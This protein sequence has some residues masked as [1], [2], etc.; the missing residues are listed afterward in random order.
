MTATP[1]R[2]AGAGA[3]LRDALRPDLSAIAP[4]AGLLRA[5]PVVV[6]VAIGMGLGQPRLALTLGVGANF[7]ATA[8]LVG[9]T[10]VR[11]GLLFVDAFGLGLATFVGSASASKETLHLLLLALWSFLAGLLVAGGLGPSTAG[12]QS[13]I[14]FVVFGRFVDS[15]GPALGLGGL[16]TLGASVEALVLVVLRLPPTLRAQRRA[17]AAA[18]RSLAALA[19]DLGSDTPTPVGN[20]LDGAEAALSVAGLFGRTDL[21]VLR[22]LVA[23]GWR[24]RVELGALRGLRRRLAGTRPEEA[25]DAPLR[26]A[27]AALE[28]IADALAH[29]RLQ[30]GAG[31]S[32]TDSGRLGPHTPVSPE[33]LFGQ[34]STHFGALGGQLRAAR[35]L[36][37]D[38]HRQVVVGR[39]LDWPQ[40]RRGASTARP[41]PRELLG[42]AL[43]VGPAA[44]RHA[45]RLAVAVPTG[46]LVGRA[47]GFPRSYWVAF[48][49]AVVLKPDY[50]SLFRSGLGRML[51]TVLGGT[52]AALIVGGLRPGAAAVVA[53]V[54][55]TGWAA[56]SVWSASFA[57]AMAFMTALVLILLSTTQA[58]TLAT[59]LDRLVDTLTGGA[60]A[61]GVYL[62][63]PTWSRLDAQRALASLIDAEAHYLGSVLGALELEE[64]NGKSLAVAARATRLAFSGAEAAVRRSL[65]EPR[66]QRIDARTGA[67]TLAITR[68][69]IEVTHS[70]RI[71]A[72]EGLRVEQSHELADF[73]EAVGRSLESSGEALAERA[74]PPAGGDLRAR[75]GRLRTEL[76]A[77]G[78]SD[79]LALQFDEVVDATNSLEALVAA[80]PQP[81]HEAPAPRRWLEGRHE[82]GSRAARTE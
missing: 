63:W 39:K 40:H 2:V 36:A 23:E 62:L 61:L 24:M 10:R 76:G 43:H 46:E 72:Q 25:L 53:L 13:V 38:A 34:W 35:K 70:L 77:Q 42:R 14:A 51:G 37:D 48:A 56:Y 78:M 41:Q 15:A 7:V 18:Y 74:P 17:V 69:L 66:P 55:F 67:G 28:E 5:L 60:L 33:P 31:A 32:A 29:R 44:L 57:A 80:A 54:A 26:A 12:V 47:L 20:A 79:V 30:T 59:A 21:R 65:S 64:V 8:S 82:G 9:A 6:M 73:A 45:V 50:S 16:V 3:S 49:V 19:L 4:W 75:Y 52:A 1:P 81:A 71:A 58:D 11:A 68:R 22:A 27:S